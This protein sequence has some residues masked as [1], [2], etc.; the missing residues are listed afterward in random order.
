MMINISILKLTDIVGIYMGQNHNL[1]S[2]YE[3][4]Q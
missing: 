4:N 3:F 1:L 2:K